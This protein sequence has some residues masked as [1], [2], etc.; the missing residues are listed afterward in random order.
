[1]LGGGHHR[2]DQGAGQ[3][4][5]DL[6]DDRMRRAAQRDVAVGRDQRLRLGRQTAVETIGHGA[7]ENQRG[8]AGPEPP[9][10]PPADLRDPR[11]PV[12]DFLGPFQEQGQ[13]AVQLRSPQ[14]SHPRHALGVE[15]ASRQRLD[16]LG[17]EADHAALRQTG[18]GAMDD[19]A[20]VV[21]LRHVDPLR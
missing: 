12:G 7:G 16:R 20:E 9:G 6:A 18:D 5:Q 4:P 19:I 17:R 3:Q 21:G 1:M 10:H 8:R 2:D 14:R 15:R 13:R 11:H